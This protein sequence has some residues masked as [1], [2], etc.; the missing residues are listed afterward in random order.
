MAGVTV[1]AFKEAGNKALLP[2][3]HIKIETFLFISFI[4]HYHRLTNYAE[5]VLIVPFF[6]CGNRAKK[7][8][9]ISLRTYHWLTIAQE[10]RPGLAQDFFNELNLICIWDAHHVQDTVLDVLPSCPNFWR[11]TIPQHIWGH[12]AV[13]FRFCHSDPV[14]RWPPSQNQSVHRCAL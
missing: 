6:R 12:P 1:I 14:A 9:Y 10:Q 3:D 13:H 8:K 2:A 5:L 4:S 7:M 11:P